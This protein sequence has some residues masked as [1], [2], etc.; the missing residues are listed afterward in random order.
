MAHVDADLN[1]KLR[2]NEGLIAAGRAIKRQEDSM[3]SDLIYDK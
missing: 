1:A 3:M 2:G